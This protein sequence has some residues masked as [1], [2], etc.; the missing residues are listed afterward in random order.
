MNDGFESSSTEVL[1]LDTGLK[2]FATAGGVNSDL[3]PHNSSSSSTI[4]FGVAVEMLA[5]LELEV[6]EEFEPFEVCNIKSFL[7]KGEYI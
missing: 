2:G 5:D 7:R 6:D 4:V 3:G 1:D